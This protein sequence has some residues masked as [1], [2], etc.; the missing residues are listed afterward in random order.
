[1]RPPSTAGRNELQSFQTLLQPRD[2]VSVR[3]R[4][5]ERKRERALKPRR[6]SNK[7]T[8]TEKR[9]RGEENTVKTNQ[10]DFQM[11]RVHYFSHI[12]LSS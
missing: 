8:D 9:D 2:Q 7:F 3:G 1:M 5:Q 10:A 11:L 6:I 4:K 12:V